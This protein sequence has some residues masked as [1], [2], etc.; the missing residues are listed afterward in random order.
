MEHEVELIVRATDKVVPRRHLAETNRHR[1]RECPCLV[2]PAV[3]VVH[4]GEF[5][6][7]MLSG[8]ETEHI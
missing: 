4:R 6:V 2:E 8:V 5:H 3:V 1:S 7:L